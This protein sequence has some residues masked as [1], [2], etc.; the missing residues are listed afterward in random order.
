MDKKNIKRLVYFVILLGILLF[1]YLSVDQNK[2][3]VTIANDKDLPV[4]ELLQSKRLIYT[5][6]AECRMDCR[7]ISEQEI[8]ETLEKGRINPIKSD[9]ND[10]PCP[11]YAVENNTAD[12]QTVRI[13][14]AD[15]DDVVKV[16]TAIDLKES[17]KCS[18]K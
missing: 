8:K 10:Q 13:V 2:S 1:R 5:K 4:L 7:F 15:C 17:H 11:T 14:F 12:G 3:D 18:C 9:P 6:H 16:V